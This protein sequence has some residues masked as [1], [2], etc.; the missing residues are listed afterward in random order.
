MSFEIKVSLKDEAVKKKLQELLTK[1]S[2]T[3][4]LLNQIGHTLI[5]QTEE[6]FENEY[7]NK[8]EDNC[9]DRSV[10]FCET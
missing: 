5:N 6:N 4:A 10:L 8:V 9:L 7:W 3:R 1:V 2:D